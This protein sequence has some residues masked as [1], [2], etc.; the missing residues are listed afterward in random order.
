[1]KKTSLFAATL[2]AGV[3]AASAANAGC[4]TKYAKAWSDTADSAK[5]YVLETIV[6]AVDWGAWPGYVATGKPTGYTIKSQS[7]KC[8]P[9]KAKGMILCNGEATLCSTK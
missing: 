6:Q 4:Q 2:V 8:G 3:V 9:D 1:M 5:W 7:Y